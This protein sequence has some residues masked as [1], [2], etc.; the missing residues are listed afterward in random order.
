M[1][2]AIFR[3]LLYLSPSLKKKNQNIYKND[4]SQI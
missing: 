4:D 1:V 2:A 3:L